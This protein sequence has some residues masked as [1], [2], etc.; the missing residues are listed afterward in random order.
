M[1]KIHPSQRSA[2]PP[3]GGFLQE[4]PA[5]YFEVCNMNEI[6]CFID[7]RLAPYEINRLSESAY[8]CKLADKH[9]LPPEPVA[10]LS[11]EL[12]NWLGDNQPSNDNLSRAWKMLISKT[13]IRKELI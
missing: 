10:V 11:S 5:F 8:L 7:K 2:R 12:K 9:N 3:Q 1:L 13:P 4:G 6:T